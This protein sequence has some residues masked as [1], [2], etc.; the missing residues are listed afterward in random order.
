MLSA[1]VTFSSVYR[2]LG[3]ACN[4]LSMG[5]A[6]SHRASSRA[7]LTFVLLCWLGWEKSW[8]LGFSDDFP[9]A[10]VRAGW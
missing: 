9:L 8:G 7:E 5:L 1:V 10:D 3:F 4:T 6:A 2:C